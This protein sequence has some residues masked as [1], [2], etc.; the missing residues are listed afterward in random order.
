MTDIT[1]DFLSGLGLSGYGTQSSTETK[2]AKGADEA[3]SE[4]N[5]SLSQ[6]DFLTLMV[7]Q[8]NNQDPTKPM[9]NAEFVS[10]M[11]QFSTVTGIEALTKSFDTLS[12]S[13]GQGLTLQAASLVGDSVLVP[14]SSIEVTEGQSVSGAVD[15]EASAGKVTVDVSDSS[16]QIIRS[17]DLGGLSAGLQEFTWDG[18]KKDGSAAPAGTYK[19]SV[20]A[21]TNGATEALT[22]MLN[23]EV[24][25]VALDSSGSG[26]KLNVKGIGE[27]GVSDV[28]RIGSAG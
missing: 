20:N 7:T 10:E 16:G 17:I 28:Y 24:K 23:G 25:S 11:A 26:V 9:D 15:L 22:T 12:Q 6:S 5:D 14:G 18:L 8:L 2:S 13:L 3:S 1:T 27:V 21:V 4:S 19:I